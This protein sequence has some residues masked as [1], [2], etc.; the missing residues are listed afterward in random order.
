MKKVVY[1]YKSR[2]LARQDYSLVLKDKNSY[3]HYIPIKQIDTL[4]CFGEISI[5]KRCLNNKMNI[6]I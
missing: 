4:I 6:I 1:L 5:N 3:S 2:T